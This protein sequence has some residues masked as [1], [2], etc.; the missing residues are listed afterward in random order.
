MSQPDGAPSIPE[1]I[2][3]PRQKFLQIFIKNGENSLDIRKIF[4]YYKEAVRKG[5]PYPQALR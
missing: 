1:K 5:F 2:K 4:F 3:I